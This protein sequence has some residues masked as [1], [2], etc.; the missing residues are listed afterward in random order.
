MLDLMA[1]AGATVSLEPEAL[2]AAAVE[3]TGLD[4]VGPDDFLERLDVLCRSLRHEARLNAAGCLAQSLLLTGL[5]RNRLLLEDLV[6][7][8]PE[9][10]AVEISRPIIIC[11]LPRTGTTH[12]HNLLSADP[13]LRSPSL[14]GEPRARPGRGRAAC[15]G[16]TRS[17]RV[18]D[19]ERPSTS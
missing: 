8:H 1:E 15:A 13:A 16:S 4:D 3:E 12:L 19:R 11:G 5:L 2:I 18:P 9:I 14:L 6:A 17:A 10:L 7:R